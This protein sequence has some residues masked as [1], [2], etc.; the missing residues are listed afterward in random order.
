VLSFLRVQDFAIIEELEI[1]LAAGLT[2]LTGETGAGKSIVVDALALAVGARAGTEAIRHGAERAEVHAT[3][4][5]ERVPAAHAWLRAQEIDCDGECILRRVVGRDGRSRAFINGQVVPLQGLRELGEMLVDIH[6]QHEFQA[7]VRRS[8]QRTLL[9]G[10]GG[11]AQAVNDVRA[12]CAAW[13]TLRDQREQLAASG[14]DRDARLE[15]LRYQVRELEALGLKPGEVA[16]LMAEQ[17]R[18]ANAGKLAAGA[19]AALDLIYESDSF[20]AHQAVA[21]AVGQIRP[22]AAVDVTLESPRELLDQATIA[23]R[24]A[25][26]SLRHYLDSMEVDPQRRDAVERRVATIEELARKHRASP[27]ELPGLLGRLQEELRALERHA[28]SLEEIER[29]L[30]GARANYDRCAGALTHAREKAARAL[31]KQ[32]TQLMQTLGLQGGKFEARV[33]ATEAGDPRTDGDDEVEFLVSANPGQPPRPIA[34]VASGGELSR[35]SLAVQVASA[36]Q[37]LSSC[38]IFDEVDAGVG[39]AVAEMVGRQLASLGSRTQ[40]LC[41]TH[42]P[43]VAS[44][45]SEHLRVSKLTDGRTTRTSVAQL[46]G[47]ERVEELARMLGGVEVSQKARDHAREMLKLAQQVTRAR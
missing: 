14:R 31:T 35:I 8:S 26:D 43:Q 32:V 23:L 15:L 39:G 25:A 2:A 19:Q 10:H 34:K 7:L 6:G 12:A 20:S 47:P 44:Q 18:L 24:E 13:S 33:A 21:R 36:G 22:L 3:F 4:D 37:A 28:T 38:M 1:E 5:V 27:E 42:L 9:D 46:R 29:R 45:A 11:H 16:E 17:R 41:V 40:V 30:A